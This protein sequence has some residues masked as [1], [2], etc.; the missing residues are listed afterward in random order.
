[1][2]GDLIRSSYEATLLLRNSS[3][4]SNPVVIKA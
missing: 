4:N 2:F 3:W 1:M